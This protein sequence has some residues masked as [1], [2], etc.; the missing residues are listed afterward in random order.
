[1][2]Y[3]GFYDCD[4]YDNNSMVRGVGVLGRR[5]DGCETEIKGCGRCLVEEK[6]NEQI[7]KPNIFCYMDAIM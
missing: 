4:K 3:S 1:M 7:L 5:K 6:V 2:P